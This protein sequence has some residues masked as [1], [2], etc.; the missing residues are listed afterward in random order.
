MDHFKSPDEQ[1]MQS[2]V[3]PFWP[4]VATGSGEN[5]RSRNNRI[6]LRLVIASAALLGTAYGSLLGTVI[7]GSGRTTP[8]VTYYNPSETH[9]P[10]TVNTMPVNTGAVKGQVPCDIN[11]DPGPC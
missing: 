1:D 3:N 2:S 10:T 4:D 11:I 6:S 7:T 5:S 8:Q 9:T